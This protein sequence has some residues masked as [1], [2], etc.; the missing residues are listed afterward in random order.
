MKHRKKILPKI[1]AGIALI[2]IIIGIVG[3]W[4]LVIVSS[5]WNSSGSI[6]EEELQQYIESLSWST[7]SETTIDEADIPA[8]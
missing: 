7:V 3:T 5:L 2:A 1:M 8:E 4:I 6:S